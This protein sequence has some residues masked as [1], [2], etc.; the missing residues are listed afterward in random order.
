MTTPIRT[1]ENIQSFVDQWRNRGYERGESQPFWLALLRDVLNVE[2]PETLICFENRVRLSN[3][4]FIDAY[5]ESTNVLIEQ[6]SSKTDLRRPIHQSD[7]SLVDS[8]T[9]MVS[10]LFSLYQT[11]SAK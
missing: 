9:A 8:D 5:I 7:P 2:Q 4:S 11:I 6:K 1:P 3:T 10:A